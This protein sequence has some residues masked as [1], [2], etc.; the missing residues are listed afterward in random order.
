MTEL[1]GRAK[2][3]VKCWNCDGYI[4][5]KVLVAQGIDDCPLCEATSLLPS[6]PEQE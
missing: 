1:K 5:K 6:D 3:Y 4:G 2:N